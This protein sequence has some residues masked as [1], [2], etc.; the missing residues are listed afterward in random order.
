[1]GNSERDHLRLRFGKKPAKPAKQEASPQETL[2]IIKLS[3]M[4]LAEG[5]DLTF[6]YGEMTRPSPRDGEV[7]DNKYQIIGPLGSGGA[8]EVYLCE[9]LMVGDRVALKV[10]NTTATAAP[11]KAWRFHLEAQ[12]TASIKHPNVITIHDFDFT[13]K[14]TPFIVMELLR[15]QTLFGE[16]KRQGRF[17]LRRAIQI[18]TPIC[19]ALNVA[20]LRNIIHRDLKPANVV[21]HRMDDGAE[22]VK[23]IDFGIAKRHMDIAS[24]NTAP[25]LLVGT[26]AYMAPERCL[27]EPY[28]ARADIY[29]LGLILY[30]M[31][32]GRHPFVAK[33]VTAM[34]AKQIS[35]EP[36]SLIK[37]V[38]D[39]PPEIEAVIFK[40]L[41]K[42]PDKRYSTTLE[43]ADELNNSF[44]APWLH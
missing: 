17:P 10:L 36:P 16:L 33:T 41:A 14:G 12:T 35:E 29:N 23:L 9:R 44:F 11:D 38:P 15:G 25:G 39:L 7:I 43:F 20:H 1:M 2:P 37:Q 5:P 18:I 40:A 34:M 8:S 3:E 6:G 19:S 30:E 28:D 21:L 22:V 27:E 4:N 31:V 26:P 32:A 42:S 13:E 24:M